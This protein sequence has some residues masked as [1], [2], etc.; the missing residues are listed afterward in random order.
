MS[1]R[2]NTIKAI[3]TRLI[4]L[5][6]QLAMTAFVIIVLLG[7]AIFIR[8]QSGPISHP[9]IVDFVESRVNQSLGN[10][11]VEIGS[12]SIGTDA[13]FVQS[14]VSFT[15]TILRDLEGA[16]LARLPVVEVE[17]AVPDLFRGN[18]RPLA[19]R[20][21]G[22][23][24]QVISD[25]NGQ[26]N[27]QLNM[28]NDSAEFNTIDAAL[29]AFDNVAELSQLDEI[30]VIDTIIDIE[31]QRTRQTFHFENAT[32]HL[33]RAGDEFNA[34]LALSLR[35]EGGQNR[36]DSPSTISL[37]ITHRLGAMQSQA[38]VSF[39]HVYLETLSDQL[40]GNWTLDLPMIESDLSGMM[41][42]DLSQDWQ[43]DNFA[44]VIEAA[45]DD[46]GDF[47]HT[48]K[49]IFTYSGQDNTF[50]IAHLDIA[51]PF[52]VLQATGQ[53]ALDYT[54]QSGLNAI[55]ADLA[56][57][58]LSVRESGGLETPLLLTNGIIKAEYDVKARRFDLHQAQVINDK[59]IF[60]FN[61][62]HWQKDDTAGAWVGE[63]KM[64][65]NE[66]SVADFMQLWPV[67]VKPEA[68]EWMQ[69]QI[70][71]GVFSTLLGT[72]SLQDDGLTF[73]ID[74]YYND[75]Y[76]EYIPG[77]PRVE[78]GTGFG[79]VTQSDLDVHLDSG[80]VTTADGGKI[81]L[82]DSDF[83]I[84]NLNISRA[85]AIFILKATGSITSTLN[86][87]DVDKFRFLSKIGLDTDIG[88]GQV[89]ATGTLTIPLTDSLTTA[90]VVLD[91][92]GYIND[93]NSDNLFEGH[94]IS[95][96]SIDFTATHTD[97]I[98]EGPA[99]LDSIVAEGAWRMDFTQTD[100]Q[101]SYLDVSVALSSA[102][103]RTFGIDLPAGYLGGSAPST[104]ALVLEKGQRMTYEINSELRGLGLSVPALGWE[105]PRG[106]GGSLTIAGYLTEPFSV[107][108]LAINTN[109]LHAQGSISFGGNGGFERLAL[110]SFILDGVM[111]TSVTL[112]AATDDSPAQTI[113][114]GG[115]ADL[116]KLVLSQTDD[117]MP[118]GGQMQVN[119]DSFQITE[120]IALTGFSATIAPKG[121][122]IGADYGVFSGQVNGGAPVSG[123][124]SQAEHGLQVD[125]SAEDVGGLLSSAGLLNGVLHG[126]GWMR[127]IPQAEAGVYSGE[128]EVDDGQLRDTN[129]M[130]DVFNSV[131]VIG[132]VQQIES[133][134]VHFEQSK[135]DFMVRPNGVIINNMS[136]IGGSVGLTMSGVYNADDK[137]VDFE[138][139]MTPFYAL[140]GLFE[141]VF[142]QL[143][144]RNRGGG[145]FSF[146]YTVKGSFEEP[147]IVVNPVSIFAPGLF[148]E[149]FR[150]QNKPT[151]E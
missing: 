24:L 94:N 49:V 81:D 11:A 51:T 150:P 74:F 25:Q 61:G 18:F 123:V 34:R 35:N 101:K 19:L 62:V 46:T 95:A 131:S 7:I 148:R 147:K 67:D 135:G 80:F 151:L 110:D 99:M 71:R 138:G 69:D 92:N 70:H 139:E 29:I 52:G 125:V 112:I 3:G 43:V 17:L 31:D 144:A 9:R 8:V 119:F 47:A 145:L 76:L 39:D 38:V 98:I 78:Q 32:L 84:P 106:Q 48:S 40:G 122:D 130:I 63:Y 42:F 136:A 26:F 56:I 54:A 116:R 60:T 104:L 114:Q 87:L 140:N 21:S 68:R 108:S 23:S 141:R 75:L 1:A 118:D 14:K 55:S 79:R 142:G 85:P 109:G 57:D 58:Q 83:K 41:R 105:K 22:V 126:T 50:D 90:D 36:A 53:I 33:A 10:I 16:E 65:S 15:D 64:A 2:L 127:L 30:S 97:I 28:G 103:L 133:H 45:R 132:L 146:T 66:I 86:L 121:T 12:I 44:G 143:S 91:F 13:G 134:G 102:N 72:L 96:E 4:R 73:G 20:L 111:D 100:A 137:V 115:T 113:L 149:I 120:G 124:L 128:F 27:L 5:F 89:F 117:G 77:L 82:S 107:D 93:F 6:F 88:E 37:D 129:P 59:T